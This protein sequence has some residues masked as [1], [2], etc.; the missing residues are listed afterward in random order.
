VPIKLHTELF[1]YKDLDII[2]PSWCIYLT[3]LN[4]IRILSNSYFIE[5]YTED[6]AIRANILAPIELELER[7]R[8]TTIISNK[9]FKIVSLIDLKSVPIKGYKLLVAL[10]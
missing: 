8:F 5:F 7:T 9:Y 10:S 2:R 6:E 4:I 3:F 1:R